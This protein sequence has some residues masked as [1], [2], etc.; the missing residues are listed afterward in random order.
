MR[1]ASLMLLA[2][3]E[4]A[5]QATVRPVPPP[6][7]HPLAVDPIVPVTY[8]DG[9]QAFGSLTYPVVPPPPNG[10]PLVVFV[11]PLG[12]TRA[13]DP[14]LQMQIA[15]QGYV[16]WSYDVRAHGQSL[17]ANPTHPNA[18]STL[19]GPVER[20][21]LAEQILFVANAPNW[22]ALVDETRV[23]VVGTSQG[24]VHAWNAA[25]WSGKPLNVPGRTPLTFPTISCA[26]AN[27]YVA[28][29][30]EDWLRDGTY[31]SSWFLEAIAGSYA[32]LPIDPILSAA[33][34]SAFLAQSPQ[35]LAA[36]FAAEGRGIA[37]ELQ[38]SSV[39][40]MYSHAYHD[41]IDSPMPTLDL[42][43]TMSAPRRVL[44]STIGHNTPSNDAER[45]YRD[46][47]ALRWLHR[48]LWNE[49]NEVDQEATY[50]LSEIPLPRTLREDPAY[51]WSRHHGGDPLAA[52]P[53]T[54]LWLDATGQLASV[55]PTGPQASASVVQA[56]NP[57]LTFT[58]QSYLYAPG[59]RDL[60]NVLRAC[61]LDEELYTT[62][63]PNETQLVRSPTLHLRVTPQDPD[64]MLAALLTVQAPNTQEEVM[65]SSRGFG[66]TA[67][68][69]GVVE[70][71]D[72][73]L[74]PIAARIP[75][76]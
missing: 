66:N 61:P 73:S 29:P 70:E 51:A 53:S 31:W 2:A 54:R 34:T 69:P 75:A 4:L 57:L 23:A 27:D 38:T 39:P 1:L 47:L 32:G 13:D 8:S 41:R 33:A 12:S 3:C 22:S 18:G 15:G 28:E 56:L 37:A 16:V 44:M 6:A 76:G 60:V 63:L 52:G 55:Q 67:S 40:V 42:L 5:A 50:V 25:A 59:A 68:T 74:P 36:Y 11:H 10:W 24:G 45:E 14:A 35:Q 26:V 20:C 19:W 64:W 65:L 46:G 62:V 30:T 43:Q 49:A 9:Y 48:Y 7:G 58:A 21:D 71:H 17:L 72:V